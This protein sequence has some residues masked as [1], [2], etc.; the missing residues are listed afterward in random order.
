[1]AA[2]NS[3]DI[4]IISIDWLQVC[5]KKIGQCEHLFEISILCIFS[6]LK[7]GLVLKYIKQNN[8]AS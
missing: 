6:F 7:N 3:L 4:S 8:A 5:F 2:D 1:M